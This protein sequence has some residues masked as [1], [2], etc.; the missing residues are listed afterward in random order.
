MQ[1]Y[2][3]MEAEK[4]KFLIAEQEQKVREKEAE[5]VRKVAIINMEKELEQK[6]NS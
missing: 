3:Q 2:E 4:T 6:G 1:N 5:T